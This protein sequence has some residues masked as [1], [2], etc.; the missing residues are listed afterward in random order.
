[1]GLALDE[2][3]EDEIVFQDGVVTLLADSP[4]QEQIIAAGGLN[5]D[6]VQDPW[7]G[8]GFKLTLAQAADCSSGGCSGC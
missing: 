8:A 5:V 2:P 1:M 7:G 3:K 6:F 4:L